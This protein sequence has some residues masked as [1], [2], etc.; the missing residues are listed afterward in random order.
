LF[1]FIFLTNAVDQKSA[2]FLR[3]RWPIWNGDQVDLVAAE[4]MP[5]Y[6]LE[7]FDPNFIHEPHREFYEEV[8]SRISPEADYNLIAAK[9]AMQIRDMYRERVK[10]VEQGYKI[11]QAKHCDVGS[12]DY[13]AW[14]TPSRDHRIGDTIDILSNLFNM[15][16]DGSEIRDVLATVVLTL[17]DREYSVDDL[18]YV[19]LAGTYSS[20]PNDP[21]SRRWGVSLLHPGGRRFI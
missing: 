20:D 16:T 9:V 14:S 5:Q 12:P 8:F 6:S 10:V 1:E 2:G 13:E 21:P 18:R 15:V 11:C 4:Q 17:D 3:M 19:W 7:Q